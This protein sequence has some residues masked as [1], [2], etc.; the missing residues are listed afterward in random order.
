[1]DM[2]EK[3]YVLSHQGR[4]IGQYAT[5]ALLWDDLKEQNLAGNLN[6]GQLEYYLQKY[7]HMRFQCQGS[8]FAISYE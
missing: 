8:W 4:A 3:V 2:E 5:L 7:A 1:M 6:V